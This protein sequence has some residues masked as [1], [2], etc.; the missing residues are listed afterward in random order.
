MPAEDVLA[1]LV[2]C[3]VVLEREGEYETRLDD[4]KAW[5]AGE[6]CLARWEVD[7][8]WY[9]ARVVEA[10]SEGFTRVLFVDYGNQDDAMALVRTT[11]ELGEDDVK[12]RHVDAVVKQT[13]EGDDAKPVEA[14]VEESGKIELKDVDISELACCV[15]AKLK[16][17]SD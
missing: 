3:G 5:S 1:G 13:F 8:V 15:C 6:T 7:G 9:R 16:K 14:D 11:T 2:D 4:E 12:D 10:T 17:V